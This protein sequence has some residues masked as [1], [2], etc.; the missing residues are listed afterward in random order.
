MQKSSFNEAII[1]LKKKSRRK[2]EILVPLCFGTARK[3]ICFY[4]YHQGV[5]KVIYRVSQLREYCLCTNINSRPTNSVARY[6]SVCLSV[7]LFLK[8]ETVK[9]YVISLDRLSYFP[10]NCWIETQM[11][12]FIKAKGK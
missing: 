7:C 4:Y 9:L 1:N 8:V 6:L 12:F 2:I 11:V 3:T 5:I 10:V